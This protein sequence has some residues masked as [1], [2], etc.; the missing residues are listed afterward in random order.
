MKE[1]LRS[2]LKIARTPRYRVN[3]VRAG[4][5][6]IKPRSG[7]IRVILSPNADCLQYGVARIGFCC[8]LAIALRSSEFKLK[9]GINRIPLAP[10]NVGTSCAFLMAARNAGYGL[11]PNYSVLT[12]NSLPLRALRGG[13]ILLLITARSSLAL[14]SKMKTAS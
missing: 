13:C 10:A 4:K 2:G 7:R 8:S 3:R 11:P 12:L 5:A 1:V 6:S 9:S 14:K